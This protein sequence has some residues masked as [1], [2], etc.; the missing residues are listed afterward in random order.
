MSF[1]PA[2]YHEESTSNY[3]KLDEGTYSFRVLSEAIVGLEYWHVDGAKRTP[4]RIHQG[5]NIPIS[6]LNDY[7]DEGKLKMPKLFWAFA[8]FNRNDNRIQILEITQ[9]TIRESILSLVN[10]PKWGD[11]K[12]YDITIVSTGKKFDRTYT[13]TP[14]PKEELDQEILKKFKGMNINLDALFDGLDP[15]A[16]KMM[17]ADETEEENSNI[18]F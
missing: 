4:V 15:F 9:K 11:P 18:P 3:M 12:E 6:D 2:N 10:N 14:D 8:V 1:L 17:T 7:D 13:V 5:V 16:S